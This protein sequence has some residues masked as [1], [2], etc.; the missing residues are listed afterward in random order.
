[1]KFSGALW[2]GDP[3]IL[4][5]E[6]RLW[7]LCDQLYILKMC[8]GTIFVPPPEEWWEFAVELNHFPHRD[9]HYTWTIKQAA[10]YEYK[11]LTS[12]LTNVLL[13]KYSQR[14]KYIFLTGEILNPSPWCDCYFLR[15]FSCPFPILHCS[16]E[17]TCYQA[18]SISK[19]HDRKQKWVTGSQLDLSALH[20]MTDAKGT[21]Y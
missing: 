16:A 6:I 15:G 12:S 1:M 14:R 7:E 4:T 17:E 3:F 5:D 8:T 19:C 11:H 10:G 13:L 21:L 20:I 9:G 18:S 2:I